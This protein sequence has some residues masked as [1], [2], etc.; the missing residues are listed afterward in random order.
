MGPEVLEY[1]VKVLIPTLINGVSLINISLQNGK[2][3]LWL[4]LLFTSLGYLLPNPKLK[5]IDKIKS[6]N[7]TP[8][9]SISLS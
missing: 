2:Q 4:V 5:N 9:S 7:Q 3:S 8:T 6:V 1:L